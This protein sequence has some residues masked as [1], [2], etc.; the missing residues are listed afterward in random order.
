MAGKGVGIGVGDAG[1]SRTVKFQLGSAPLRS[2][3]GRRTSM[4][5]LAFAVTV[6]A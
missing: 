6:I 4:V 1:R 3:L 5:T 2:H